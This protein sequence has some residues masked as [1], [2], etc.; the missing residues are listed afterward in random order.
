MLIFVS[1][2][3]LLPILEPA[4]EVRS[5]PGRL[6][7]VVQQRLERFGVP[8]GL[9]VPEIEAMG[10]VVVARTND[11]SVV[12]TMVDFAKAVPYYL[13]T[14]S[15]WGERELHEAEAKLE[16]TPCRCTSRNVVFPDLAT[17]ELLVE[18]WTDG[19]SD[20]DNSS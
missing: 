6:S 9:I 7:Y 14:G 3:S 12:G 19:A 1:G 17:K 5:L 8:T 10:D 18:R 2:A 16:G 20:G 15:R 13:P 11:R 4:Q